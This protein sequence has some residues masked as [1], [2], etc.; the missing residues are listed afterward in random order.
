LGKLWVDNSGYGEL[1]SIEANRYASFVK[2]PG[3]TRGLGFAG[4]Y[5]LVG[6]SRILPRF[7]HYAPGLDAEKSRC[8]VHLVDLKRA[9]VAG[10]LFW[11]NGDQIFAVEF[12]PADYAGG[13]PFTRKT[14]TKSLTQFFYSFGIPKLNQ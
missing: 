1:G 6:T 11:P 8:G 5:A 9:V 3:W 4:Q 12:L 14:S 2:L 10:S 13:F 7:S